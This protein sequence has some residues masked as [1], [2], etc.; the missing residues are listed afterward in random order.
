MGPT[1][2]L[3]NEKSETS[4]SGWDVEI[5]DTNCEGHLKFWAGRWKEKYLTLLPPGMPGRCAVAT[6]CDMRK[7]TKLPES[8]VRENVGNKMLGMDKI[9][10]RNRVGVVLH[11]AFT[12]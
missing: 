1:W 10:S 12:F 9:Y 11:T 7:G 5:T 3:K 2:F 8:G 4:V 6:T